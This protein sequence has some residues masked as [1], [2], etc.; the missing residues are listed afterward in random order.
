MMTLFTM[1]VNYLFNL[2]MLVPS[3]TIQNFI[4]GIGHPDMMKLLSMPINMFS[5]FQILLADAVFFN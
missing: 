2:P 1:A 5:V 4:V 3:P